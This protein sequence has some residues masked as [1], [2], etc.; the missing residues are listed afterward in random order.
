MK[1]IVKA[2]FKVL[3]QTTTEEQKRRS[4]ICKECPQSKYKIYL[5]FS[6]DK[7]SEVKGMVCND[8]G[9]PLVAKIRS[10]KTCYKWE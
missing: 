7:L 4:E 10:N 5:D 2:W 3:K 8:C 6:N 9:C 1:E